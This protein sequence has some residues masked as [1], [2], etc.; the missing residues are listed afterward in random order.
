M[1]LHVTSSSKKTLKLID[2][3]S[4]K[5]GMNVLALD[6]AMMIRCK[7]KQSSAVFNRK[8]MILFC[9]F[10]KRLARVVWVTESNKDFN[11]GLNDIELQEH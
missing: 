9:Y 7:T 1:N 5:P 8:S 3:V 11:V 6:R 4:S 2:G 10:N